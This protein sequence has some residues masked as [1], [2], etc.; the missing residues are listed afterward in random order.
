MARPESIVVVGG[1]LAGLRAAER[2]RERRYLG[3][4]T[5][6]GEEPGAPYNRPPLSKQLIT[7][8]MRQSDLRLQTF[9]R[10][11]AELRSGA[12]A[13]RLDPAR[14]L[15]HLQDGAS[16][17][18]DGLVLATGVRAR[19][20][21]EAPQHDDRI[22]GLRTLE[23]LKRLQALLADARRVLVVGGGFI[24]CEAA[25]SLRRR[26]LDVTLIDRSPVLLHRVL[27]PQL[28]GVL[29][30]VHR[31]AGVDVRLGTSVESWQTGRA[32]V[33]VRLHDG[34]EVRGDA[35]LIAIGTVPAVEW[36][37]DLDLDLAD[38]VACDACCRVIGLRNTVAAG[39]VARWPNLRFDGSPRR[40]EHW[41]NAVEMARAAADTLLDGAR[42][43]PFTPIPRFWSEQHG[44]KIQSV[45]M[46]SLAQEAVLVEGTLRQRSFLAA[47]LREQRVVGAIA[48]NRATSLRR[49][50]DV[51][52]AA[53]R[54][55]A[56]APLHLLHANDTTT[57]RPRHGGHR[58]MPGHAA[59]S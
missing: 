43:R 26:S 17:S 54:A 4:I 58:P 42:A 53:N 40:V 41:I 29:T 22:T 23:D 33:Q 12:R 19:T 30:D 10:L 20:V 5:I 13:E 6:V 59:A 34:T 24:G 14:R 47:H 18:Y 45:G 56:T 38:G 46:P 16:I 25:A 9:V 27:G 52:E 36:L 50:A 35:A 31:R 7:G 49:F 44:L 3:T 15:V 11:G 57:S 2:L 28:G 39:D 32:G 55:P 21:A 48:F 8:R 37:A 1:G 51:V